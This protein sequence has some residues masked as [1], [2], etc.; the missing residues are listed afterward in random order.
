VK[1]LAPFTYISFLK[2]YLSLFETLLVLFVYISFLKSRFV[3]FDIR[4]EDPFGF[5]FFEIGTK[6]YVSGIVFTPFYSSLLSSIIRPLLLWIS[7]TIS[8]T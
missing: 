7:Q 8:V 4:K 3:L 1:I 5:K 6:K 2:E